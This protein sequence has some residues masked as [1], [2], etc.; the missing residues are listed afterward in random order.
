MMDGGFQPQARLL[1]LWLQP[2]SAPAGR[3]VQR[4]ALSQLLTVTVVPVLVPLAPEA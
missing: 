1:Y 2:R 4:A 3:R